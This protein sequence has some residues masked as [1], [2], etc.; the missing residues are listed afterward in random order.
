MRA[1]KP[2][3]AGV[4]VGA[5]NTNHLRNLQ[6][7]SDFT[8]ES[9]DFQ[10][11]VTLCEKGKGPLGPIYDLERDKDGKHGRIMRYN[12]NEQRGQ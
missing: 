4:I 2:G 6:K 12:L 8:L 7:L 9:E 10:K 11:V 1:L 3:V 5:R